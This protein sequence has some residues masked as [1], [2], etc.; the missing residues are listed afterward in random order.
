MC[1]CV[2]VL[3]FVCVC[4]FVSLCVC[5]FAYICTGRYKVFLRTT[6][7]NSASS[8]LGYTPPLFYFNGDNHIVFTCLIEISPR[9]FFP[10]VCVCVFVCV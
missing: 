8:K 7:R 9:R 2:C 5:V 3:V 6:V 1:T 10:S 4:V